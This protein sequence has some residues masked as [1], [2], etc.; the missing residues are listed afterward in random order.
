MIPNREFTQRCRGSRSFFGREPYAVASCGKGIMRRIALLF[1]V[2]LML[3]S[4]A[5]S[6]VL[7][8]PVV[9]CILDSGS[10]LPDAK[11]WNFVD[12]SDDL[13]DQAGHGTKIHALLQQCAPEAEPYVL[14]CFASEAMRDGEAVVRA[15]RA[16]AGE[17]GAAVIVISWTVT[18]E[19]QQLHDAIQYAYE[20]DAIL[21]ASAGN[22]SLSTRLG[23]LVYPA[24][25]EKV[26]GVGGVNLDE[27]GEPAASLWY[28][29]SEAVYVCARGDYD[30]ERGSSFAAPRV[31]AVIAAYLGG[32]PDASEDDVRRMLKKTALDFGEPG[33]DMIYGWGY[34]EAGV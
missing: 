15:L 21:V 18:G 23:S 32:A 11:G 34:I 17:Y 8:E 26:I 9:I 3:L 2:L 28:L 10:N 13:T 29:A 12:N 27:N 14:K 5:S 1:F 33:Y 4:A 19:Q 24:A 22:L 30:G 16:A 7:A 6:S 20:S 31:A 25:W